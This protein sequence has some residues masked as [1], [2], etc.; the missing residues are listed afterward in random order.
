MSVME[1]IQDDI[2]DLDIS[3]NLL[4]QF[5]SKQN[6]VCEKYQICSGNYIYNMW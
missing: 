6:W 4:E 5:I 1:I 3:V 2:F